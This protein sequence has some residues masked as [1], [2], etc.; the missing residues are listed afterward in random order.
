[1]NSYIV[2][3]G[4][5][6][7][8]NPKDYDIEIG[9]LSLSIRGYNSLRR[10]GISTISQLIRL[11]LD[12][13]LTSLRNIGSKTELEI[14]EKL[15]D[16][17]SN[18]K[19]DIFSEEK[20]N[21]DIPIQYDIEYLLDNL[22]IDDRGWIILKKRSLN[23]T[24]EAISENLGV[25]RERIR[26]IVFEK[27][28][29][30]KNR[31][32]S[33]QKIFDLLENNYSEIFIDEKI[34][35]DFDNS[36]RMFSNKVS[37]LLEYKVS[38]KLGEKLILILR[39]IA[40]INDFK[41]LKRWDST[42]FGVCSI[43]PNIIAHPKIKKFVDNKKILQKKLT[44]AQLSNKVLT[45]FGEPLHWTE[46]SKKAEVLNRRKSFNSTALYNSLIFH[47][48]I[49]VRVDQGTYGLLEWGL[50][51]SD[52]FPD[53]VADILKREGNPLP[54]PNIY[55]K[56]NQVRKAKKASLIMTMDCHPRFYKSNNNFYGLRTWLP[57]RRKQNLLTRI[58]FTETLDSFKRVERAILHGYNVE[59]IIRKDKKL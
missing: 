10:N 4:H 27:K 54:F 2:H 3:Q 14:T 19:N 49:F 21:L 11:V 1:M 13:N 8:I 39:T 38:I 20:P 34:D 43:K 42:I 30:I 5:S 31:I 45:E 16:F 55:F 46:I 23:H 57:E 24:Y 52:Y 26:Q 6:L 50:I 56:V 35:R 29:R 59:N 15:F 22:R 7:K 28:R 44:Y 25:S 53:I 9:F 41:Y 32:L 17:V 47:N 58:E 40:E 18:Y 12:G 51:E 37:K 33:F 48:E 36:I